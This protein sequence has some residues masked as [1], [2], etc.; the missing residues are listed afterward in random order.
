MPVE[1]LHTDSDTSE[2]DN[3]LSQSTAASE[4]PATLE[5]PEAIGHVALLLKLDPSELLH[6]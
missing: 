1:L 6:V 4:V 2:F 3:W 5:D